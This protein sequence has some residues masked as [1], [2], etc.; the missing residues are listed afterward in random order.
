MGQQCK[1]QGR[2]KDLRVDGGVIQGH[3]RRHARL[4]PETLA[5]YAS[6]IFTLSIFL[7][8][9]SD[10]RDDLLSH[11]GEIGGP[12]SKGGKRGEKTKKKPRFLPTKE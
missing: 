9:G 6:Q 3:P 2:A 4:S 7:G 8:T 12:G 5:N 10:K 11:T 1:S